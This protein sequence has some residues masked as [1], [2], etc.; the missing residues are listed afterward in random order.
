M[1]FLA[2][3]MM[4]VTVLFHWVPPKTALNEIDWGVVLMIAA[5]LG[6]SEALT[7]SGAAGAFGKAI[8]EAHLSP[9]SA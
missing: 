1:E 6:F 7:Q 5:A 8:R 2:L 3:M 9:H 4:A